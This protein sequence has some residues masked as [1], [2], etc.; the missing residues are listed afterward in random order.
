VCGDELGINLGGIPPRMTRQDRCVL[1]HHLVSMLVDIADRRLNLSRAEVKERGDFVSV[2]TCLV[3]IEN[4]VNGDTRSYDARRAPNFDNLRFGHGRRSPQHVTL[5]TG[6]PTSTSGAKLIRS[7]QSI[8]S[9]CIKIGPDQH[10]GLVF[11]L[12]TSTPVC[13]R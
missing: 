8:S 6:L 11:E 3:I 5:T 7:C 4:I 1:R 10:Q 9:S 13:H 12:P 2:P